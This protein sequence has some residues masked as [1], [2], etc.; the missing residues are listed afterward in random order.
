MSTTS[1]DTLMKRLEALD[2]LLEAMRHQLK[3]RG[4]FADVHDLFVADTRKQQAEIKQR[5]DTAL[6][7][8]MSWS[9]LKSE[10]ELDFNGLVG[11][12]LGWQERLDTQTNLDLAKP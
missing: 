6:A 9:L 4:E 7:K 2:R 3:D 8:G 5:L 12:I 1:D 11:A 10:F